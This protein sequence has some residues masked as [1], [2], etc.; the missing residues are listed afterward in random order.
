M[1]LIY[2]SSLV[3]KSEFCSSLIIFAKRGEAAAQEQMVFSVSEANTFIKALPMP[4]RQLQT[5][6]VRGEISN[7]K[8]YPLRP[9][10]FYA[11]GRGSALSA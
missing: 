5:I 9:P 11:Q 2:C 3:S 7:Y 1:A 6:F 8:L 10:L 4:Y